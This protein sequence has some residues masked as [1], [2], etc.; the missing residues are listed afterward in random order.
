M[1][2]TIH[3]ALLQLLRPLLRILIREGVAFGEF[4][5]LAKQVYVDTAKELLIQSEGKA[6]SSRM[7]IMT[8][9][10]RKEVAQLRQHSEPDSAALQR[11]NRRV[12]VIEGWLN[13]SDFQQATGKTQALPLQG[14]GSFEQLV[15]R[16]SGDMPYRAMLEALQQNGIIE[17]DDAGHVHL[18]LNAYVPKN[19]EEEKLAI[20]GTDV[21]LLMET[22]EHNLKG[23][24]VTARFQRKVSYDNLSPDAVA[25]FRQMAAQDS[26]DLLL[27]FNDWLAQHDRDHQTTQPANHLTDTTERLQAG[28]GIYYFEKRPSLKHNTDAATQ[29]KD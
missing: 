10:T 4:S 16:Y 26:M 18:L 8:G 15:N 6:T 14:E 3:N 22:I 29:L 20:L 17:L 2:R 12:R 25:Q 1:K 24:E 13:D 23:E 21:A 19:D 27:K 9:L 28:V 11:Y 7:A 5:H